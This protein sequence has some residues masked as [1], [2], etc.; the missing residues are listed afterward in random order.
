MPSP[1]TSSP[2][3]LPEGFRYTPSFLAESEESGLL[4]I[5]S[6]LDFHPFE[7]QGYTAKRRIV[8]YGWEYDFTSRAASTT[9]PL[10]TFLLPLRDRAAAFANLPPDSLA[11]AVVTEYPPG[12]PIGWHRDVPQF[13]EVL[14]ISL[15]APCR[16]RFKPYRA[17]GK[18]VSVILEPRSIYIMSGPAR[19]KFQHSIPALEA[20]RYSITFRTLRQRKPRPSPTVAP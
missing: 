18:L 2:A 1:R 5:F 12:A 8:E 7:F 11:E 4:A 10:P 3:E 9:R 16:M 20:L 17:E 6:Q 19:W 13:E 15:A 14:G